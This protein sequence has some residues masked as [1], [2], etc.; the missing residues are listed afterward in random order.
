M[1]TLALVLLALA[2]WAAVIDRAVVVLDADL[3]AREAMDNCLING[4]TPATCGEVNP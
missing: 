1:K 2:L 4:G 3:A